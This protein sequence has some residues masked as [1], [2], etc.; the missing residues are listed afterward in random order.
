MTGKYRPEV[1]QEFEQAIRFLVHKIEDSGENSKPVIFH[2][3]R[4]GIYL[5]REGY[6]RNIVLA[7]MLHDL[8]EDSD[9]TE[10]EISQK[11]GENVAK[12]VKAVSFD[13]DITD[14]RERYEQTFKRGIEAGK[15]ALVIKAADI[16]DNSYYYGYTDSQQSYDWLVSGK[17]KHFVESTKRVIGRE[18]V[19]EELRKRLEELNRETFF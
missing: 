10:E 14:K 8:L 3:V 1:A 6:S 13:K 9:A 18:K 2:S 11:F 19:W 12:L 15:D 16:L 7:G 17:L 4:V 5:S